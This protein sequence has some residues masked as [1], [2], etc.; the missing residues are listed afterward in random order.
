MVDTVLYFEG[1]HNEQFRIIRSIKNR[2]GPVNEIGI[3]Q[4]LSSGLKEVSN[5]EKIFISE[6]K[7]QVPGISLFMG[8]KGSRPI[9]IEIQVLISSSNLPMPKRTVVGWEQNRLSMIIAILSSRCKINI[10]SYDVY[11]SVSGGIKIQ[12]P[13]ADLAVASALI[14]AKLNKSIHNKT[15]FIGEISLSGEIKKVANFS[16]RV[17]EA[18]KMGFTKCI[19]KEQTYDFKNFKDIKIELIYVNNMQEL[20][21]YIST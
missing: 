12:D 2:F 19:C 14:C 5:P 10:N 9:P 16:K 7:N 20:T 8:I 11:I 4:M 1:D 13:S 21:R 3:F 18:N 6:N 17:Y 15:I